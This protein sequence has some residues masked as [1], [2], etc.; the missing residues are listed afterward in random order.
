M[1]QP[2]NTKKTSATSKKAKQQAAPEAPAAIEVSEVSEAPATPTVSAAP[3][4]PAESPTTL[5]KDKTAAKAKRSSSTKPP[6]T[7]TPPAA[8][9]RTRRRKVTQQ[10][11]PAAPQL[12]DSFE[13]EQ[14]TKK[15][16]RSQYTRKKIDVRNDLLE[17]LQAVAKQK[18]K[19][20]RT[21]L[22]NYALEQA[23]N[24]LDNDQALYADQKEPPLKQAK[25]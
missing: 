20:Y 10:A 8:K 24:S 6:A 19:L 17:R 18:G 13:L 12:P 2:A 3:V 22:L 1:T 15:Q 4:A 21:G 11:T 16:R 7:A 5:T 25:Q 23:L 14:L 9:P